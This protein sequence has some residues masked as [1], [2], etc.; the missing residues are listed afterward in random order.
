[1][2]FADADR[3]TLLAIRGNLLRG[4]DQ[5]APRAAAG[6]LHVIADG[7]HTP[8]AASGWLMTILLEQVNAELR[9]RVDI[10]TPVA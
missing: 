2:G 9:Q 6:T 1:M 7:A 8:P 3:E 4:L 10:A 5:L